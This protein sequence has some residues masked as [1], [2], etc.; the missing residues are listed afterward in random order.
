[1]TEYAAKGVTISWGGTSVGQIQSFNGISLAG[2]V[3]DVTDLADTSKQFISAGLYGAEEVSVEVHLD[4]AA[5]TTASLHGYCAADILT[6]TTRALVVSYV[7]AT[8]THSASA[9]CTGF[10]PTG[11][12]GDKLTAT[13]TWQPTGT[14]TLA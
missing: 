7:P 11:S 14:I 1:M 8:I 5:T 13:I 4:P 6:G 2:E 3:L 9:I 12:V 10:T